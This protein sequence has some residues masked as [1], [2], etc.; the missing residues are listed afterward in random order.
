MK[1]LSISLTA[2]T[3]AAGSV[4][5]ATVTEGADFGDDFASAFD[6]GPLDLGLNNVEGLLSRDRLS[7]DVV[8]TVEFTVAA[9]TQLVDASFLPFAF[10]IYDFEAKIADSSGV[11][12]ASGIFSTF[13]GGTFLGG[14]VLTA[15]TYF[16]Q[17]TAFVGNGE[18]FEADYTFGLTTIE[19]LSGPSPNVV[20]LPASAPLALGGLALFGAMGWRKK[21]R[22]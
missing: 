3:L 6:I 12:I 14:N 20:P 9:G 17:A 4:S 21:K 16:L 13:G 15:G 7:E 22:A 11:T 10:D 2:L 19:D 18:A 8:D 1:L 5:A